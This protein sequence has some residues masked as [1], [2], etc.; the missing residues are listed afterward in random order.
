MMLVT[1]VHLGGHNIDQTDSGSSVALSND[2]PYPVD[3]INVLVAQK[4]T[5]S[6]G[7]SASSNF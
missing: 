4:E 5:S 3:C 1:S 7:M 6:S 2:Y